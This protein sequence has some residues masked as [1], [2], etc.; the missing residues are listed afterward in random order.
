MNLLDLTCLNDI[1]LYHQQQFNNKTLLNC[2]GSG[3]VLSSQE[4]CQTVNNIAWGLKQLPAIQQNNMIAIYCYQGWQWLV[5]DLAIVSAQ[6]ISVPIFHNISSQNLEYQLEL[7]KAQIIITDKPSFARQHFQKYTII[8]IGFTFENC[9]SFDDLS[10]LGQ[11]Q[12]QAYHQLPKSQ[13]NSL[14]TIVF[15]SGT[16]NKPKGVMLS[17]GNLISQVIDSSVFFPLLPQQKALSYLPLAHIFERM[18]MFFYLTQGISIYFVEDIAKIPL[19]LKQV[20]PNL[21]TT[22]PRML[23]KF[24]NKIKQKAEESNFLTKMLL[25]IAFN[26]AKHFNISTKTNFINSVLDLLLYKKLR[27]IFGGK[28]QMIICGGASL[29]SDIEKFLH[30]IGLAVYCGYGLTESSPVLASNCPANYQLGSVGNSFSSVKLQIAPDGELLASGKNIMLGYFCQEQE[31]KQTLKNGWLYTGDLA[32]INN[33]FLKIVGRK[34]ELLKTSN[35]KYVVAN[36]LQQMLQQQITGL[37]GSLIIAEGKPFVAVL[38]FFEP[39]S[40]PKLQ[41]QLGYETSQQNFLQSQVLYDSIAKQIAKINQQLDSWQQ[42]KKFSIITKAIS[43][44]KGQITPSYKLNT[45]I[46]QQD[47]ALEIAKFYE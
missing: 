32:E 13:E 47:F 15:T 37:L 5:C 46:L 11:K 27:A 42:I 29:P 45:K 43:I 14:A 2:L 12:N 24:F 21:F 28:V 19:Y 16:T 1:I 6:L 3:K 30:S 36:Y 17:H 4:F 18:V 20:Q 8:T 7:T 10:Q 31:T 44:E 35:G 41:K 23:E 38:L 25:K 33:G 9:L 40:L 22:V 26:R 39:E 34:K